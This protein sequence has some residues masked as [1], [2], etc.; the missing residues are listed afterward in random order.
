M[1]C[2]ELEMK[3]NE[4]VDG[5]LPEDDRRLIDEHLETC[6][7]CRREIKEIRSLVEQARRLPA[8]IEPARALWPAV[9]SRIAGA[10]ATGSE[11]WARRPRSWARPGLWAPLAAAAMLLIAVAV[12]LLIET[13]EPVRHAEETTSR[14]DL[15]ATAMLARAED[16]ALLPRS[17]LLVTLEQKR[18]R[19]P[20][21]AFVTLEENARLVDEAIA[22]VRA[23]LEESPGN[24]QLE[25]L[26]A[27]RYQQE[28]ALLKQVNR[29]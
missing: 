29:V 23:A 8:D 27:A 13:S 3:L 17:D 7:S 4:Y 21:E 28:V 24:R 20:N 6:L 25:L 16:G 15:G 12:P 5:E 18:D 9:E 2:S 26:L 19:L 14:I 11:P 1:I 10:S 22:E